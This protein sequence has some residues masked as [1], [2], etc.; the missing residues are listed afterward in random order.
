MVSS[1]TSSFELGGLCGRIYKGTIS[2]CYF[3][4]FGGPDNNYGIDLNDMQIL[5]ASSYVGFD[6]AGEVDDGME[7]V[8]AIVDGRLPKLSWQADEGPLL[9]PNPPVTTLSGSGISNDPFQIN[10]YEDFTEFRNNTSLSRGYYT[11][12]T[13]IDLSSEAF[14]TSV[15]DRYFGGHF[16]GNGHVISNITIDTGESSIINL[17]LFSQLSGSASNLCIEKIKITA[18]DDSDNIGGLCGYNVDGMISSCYSSGSVSSGSLSRNIGGLCGGNKGIIS[19]CHS[20]GSVS[21]GFYTNLLGGLSGSNSNMIINSY[22]NSTVSAGDSCRYIGGLCGNSGGTVHESYSIGSVTAG[23]FSHE[24]GGLCGTNDTGMISNS[25]STCMVL[26]KG[27]A[28][29]LGGLCGKNR[30]GTISDC[31]SNGSVSGGDNSGQL[32]GFCGYSRYGSINNCLYFRIHFCPSVRQQNLYRQY[33]HLPDLDFLFQR[34]YPT[35]QTFQTNQRASYQADRLL[36][37]RSHARHHQKH[38]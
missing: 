8:W 1:G 11:L 9:V 13:D 19:N 20:V 4:L 37:W 38:Q 21:S 25:Y 12:A 3:Y 18:G 31:Y 24:F 27:R 34:S 33:L 29:D 16:A 15:I 26:G 10:S 17:G 14:V 6:F 22:S 30:E 2:N 35:N 23:N 36:H 7:D 5:N 32:G 28:N